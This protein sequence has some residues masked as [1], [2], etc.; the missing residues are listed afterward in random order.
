MAPHDEVHVH[1]LGVVV[2]GSG[3]WPNVWSIDARLEMDSLIRLEKGQSEIKKSTTLFSRTKKPN[4]DCRFL[5]KR[6]QYLLPL[7]SPKPV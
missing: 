6:C 5:G 2:S 1:P 7:T 4:L 3:S